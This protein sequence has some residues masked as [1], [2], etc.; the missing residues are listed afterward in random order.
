MTSELAATT[1]IAA[2][3][4]VP[5]NAQ[6]PGET[7]AVEVPVQACTKCP[8]LCASRT[9]IVNGRGPATAR[10]MVVGEGPGRDEDQQG[11]SFLGAA[12]KLVARLLAEAGVDLADV[13]LTN[14]IRCRPPNNR[15]P[16]ASEVSACQPYLLEEIRQ[17]QPTVIVSVGGTALKAL[18]GKTATLKDHLGQVLTQPD[19]GI[20]LVPT[21]HPAY[22]MRGHWAEAPLVQA[23]LRKAQAIADNSIQMQPLDEARAGW[24]PCDTVEKVQAL[25]D[26][27]L[28]DDVR[29]ITV[30][31]ETTGLSWLED[32]ILCVSFSALDQEFAAVRR[33]WT[34][35][36]LHRVE[37][38]DDS[39]L[40][41]TWDEH[42]IEPVIEILGRIF[43]SPK[44]K[45]IQNS[46]FDIKFFERSPR[47]TAVNPSV[48]TVFGWKVRNLRYDPM[49]LQRLVDENLPANETVMLSLYTDMPFYEGEIKVASKNK[50]RIDLAPD[51]VLWKYAA[52]DADGLARLTEVMV[53]IAKREGVLW[54]HDNI[55][56]PMVRACWNM[57]RRGIPIDMDY[58]AR[59]CDRYRILVTEAEQAVM[60]AYG[61]GTFNLNKPADIQKVLFVDLALPRSGR[62]TPKAKECLDCSK[63]VACDLH[64]QTGKD[65]LK[66]IQ[67]AM[68]ADGLEPHPILE[69]VLN[70]KEVSKRKSVYVDGSQGDKGILRYIRPDD[71][72]HPNFFPNKADTGR[73]AAT[74]P[75]IQT[76]P[77][78]VY[79]E[80]LGEKDQLRRMFI[81]PP[82]IT[83]MELDWSQGEVWVM[84]YESGDETLLELL[85]SGRDVHGYVARKLCSLGFSRVF[86]KDAE[87]PELTDKEWAEKY[88]ELRRKA[89][90][91]VFGLDYGM[92]EVGAAERLGCTPEEASLLIDAFLS[93][94]FP[95]LQDNFDRVRA[96]MERTG[97]LS[98]RFGRL[99]HFGDYEFMKAFGQ[100]GA[101]DWEAKFRKGVNMP[102]QSGLND[103]H[104]LMQIAIDTDP[105]MLERYRI[106]L[107]V[108]DSITGL[109]K[110]EA[111]GDRD[112]MI[113][114]AWMLKERAERMAREIVLPNGEA[115]GWEIPVEIQW[116]K[117]WGRL[118]WKLSASGELYEPKEAA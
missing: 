8:A 2:V 87:E 82:G 90:V 107:A 7:A 63:D 33:G 30:D 104:S 11:K 88:D 47:D 27:L 112:H 115:L 78:K 91:F 69:A 31:S 12:G 32:E 38:T 15:T 42:E 39:P 58:F 14:A 43:A 95:G 26:Y 108:H 99:G 81:A 117:S 83:L 53:R 113:Q 40:V 55:A 9:R 67:Q 52:G 49:L 72:V 74:E 59:L 50:R 51:D 3:S 48:A 22:L 71:R 54:I 86:P 73:L 36:I 61:Q 44:P 118:E 13:Y 98:N 6:G 70:W 35:P 116:G 1:E 65:A 111:Y 23:H 24:Q 28:S 66:D 10:I 103:L 19:T 85:K 21:Y 41:P 62:K 100:R 109:V 17:I 4:L 75:P 29:A 5:R 68:K 96:V 57:T 37:K 16:K 97:V 76:I 64:D 79:D 105:V 80:V 20:P 101:M 110:G 56:M 77:K 46:I 102:I 60:E 34:V 18:Y 106:I 84:A 25:A 94:V 89:K 45:S 93:E 114:T 92:T